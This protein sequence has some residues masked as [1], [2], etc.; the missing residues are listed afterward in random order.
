MKL[1]QLLKQ[2]YIIVRHSFYSESLMSVV[3]IHPCIRI[4]VSKLFSVSKRLVLHGLSGGM[5]SD[6]N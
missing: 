6:D 1:V 4:G 5:S 2:V 3:V